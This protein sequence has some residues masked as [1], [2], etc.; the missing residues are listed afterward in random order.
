MAYI[1]SKFN[2]NIS[3]FH[4]L[5]YVHHS[6]LWHAIVI[7]CIIFSLNQSTLFLLLPLQNHIKLHVK[8]S[9]L[10]DVISQFC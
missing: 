8:Y 9:R 2:S 5:L 7:L 3:T 1:F 10:L 6:V 4:M